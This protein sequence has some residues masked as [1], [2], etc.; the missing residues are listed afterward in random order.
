MV[1][2]PIYIKIS[3]LAQN[4][5]KVCNISIRIFI[6]NYIFYLLINFEHLWMPASIIIMHEN[7]CNW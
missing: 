7:P 6:Y 2:C 1:K 5:I 3:F 4:N